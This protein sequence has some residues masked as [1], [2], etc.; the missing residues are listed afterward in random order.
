MWLIKLIWRTEI[1]RQFIKFCLV[2]SANAIIDYT[3]Y[4]M[5]SRIIGLYFLY[6]NIIAILTAMTFS[7]IFNKYWTFQNQEKQIKKQYFK[8]IIVNIIYFFLNNSIVFG[9]VRFL[10]VYDLLAKIVAIFVGLFWNFFA[11][12]YWT[13]KTN[14]SES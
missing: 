13:F 7:F 3:V 9:L 11:N 10:K 4:L 1:Y 12:R 8:F 14:N 2:G 6:A 5:L